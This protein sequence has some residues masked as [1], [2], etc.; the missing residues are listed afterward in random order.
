M[1]ISFQSIRLMFGVRCNSRLYYIIEGRS[2]RRDT[3]SVGRKERMEKTSEVSSQI[4]ALNVRNLVLSYLPFPSQYL[5]CYP[6]T[7]PSFPCHSCHVQTSLQA[8]VLCYHL[9]HS[10]SSSA[11]TTECAGRACTWP[12][13]AL[14][15]PLSFHCQR[16]LFHPSSLSFISHTLRIS[17]LILHP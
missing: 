9:R 6:S 1:V 15:S 3:S 5:Y 10:K 12:N 4:P 14:N 11:T 2:V 7:F 13:N 8:T 17:P 16:L